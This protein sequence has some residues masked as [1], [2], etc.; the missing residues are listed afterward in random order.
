MSRTISRRRFLKASAGVVAVTSSGFLERAPASA[1]KREL[2]MLS[3]NHF[4]PASDDELKRQCEGFGKQ[5]GVTVRLDTIQGRQLFAK[6]AA[7]VPSQA[8]HD[9]IVTGAADPFLSEQPLV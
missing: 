1:Q 4:V 8:G 9:I 2:T 7:E 6:R 5:A 3:F